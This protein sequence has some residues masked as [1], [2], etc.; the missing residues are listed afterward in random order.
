MPQCYRSF[1]TLLT[2]NIFSEKFP[3]TKVDLT[4]LLTQFTL[5]V[6]IQSFLRSFHTF[7][8]VFGFHRKANRLIPF[9]FIC[10]YNS[11]ALWHISWDHIQ[12][13]H[14][15][16]RKFMWWTFAPV[17]QFSSRIWLYIVLLSGVQHNTILFGVQNT[18]QICD[19]LSTHPLTRAAAQRVRAG[20]CLRVFN[21]SKMHTI[22]AYEAFVCLRVV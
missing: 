12:S 20:P 15:G 8:P 2:E 5:F 17:H 7:A 11:R 16:H 14:L 21:L 22:C 1:M 13:V 6:H 4:S 10:K 19:A 18:R 9:S 3:R